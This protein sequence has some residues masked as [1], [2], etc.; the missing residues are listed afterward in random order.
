MSTAFALLA[1]LHMLEAG[2]VPGAV[3]GWGSNIGGEATGVPSSAYYSTGV[4][5]IAGHILD[6]VVAISAGRGHSLGLRSDGTVVGWGN[7]GLGEALG[8]PTEHPYWSNGPVRIAGRALGGITAISAGGSFSL[9]VRTNGTVVVWGEGLSERSHLQ[10]KMPPG[11]TNV[12]AVAAGWDY[13]MVLTADGR[14]V[15][16]GDRRAPPGLSN[17]VAIA[18]GCERYA[19]ALALRRDGTVAKWTTS[20]AE[21]PVPAEATNVT[22]IAAGEAHSLVLRRDGT[23][24]GWGSN[25]FGEAT[26]MPTASFPNSSSGRVATSGQVL[27]NVLAIAAGNGYSLALKTDGTVVAWG[28]FCNKQ[29]A[30]P[31]GLRNAT[32]IAA[33]YNFCLAITTNYSA[34]PV[35]R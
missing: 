2:G 28:R 25:Q 4:V 6:S 21:E 20:G 19:P 16:W 3:V 33:G 15:S 29:A 14:I 11:L 35:K 22:S 5:M 17:I 32:A 34:W 10:R 27:S 31:A 8:F 12:V 7:N 23:V 1:S 24:V 26:G 13:G 18:A 30:A 9:A